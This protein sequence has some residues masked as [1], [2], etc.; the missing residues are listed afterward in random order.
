MK[1]RS[2]KASLKTSPPSLANVVVRARLI[3][4]LADLVAPA[5]WLQAPSGTGKSTLAASYV[6]EGARAVAWYRFDERDNDP[7]FFFREFASAVEAQCR[8]STALPKFLSDDHANP[9]QFARRFFATLIE[10]LQGRSV[11][12][13]DDV[14]QLTTEPM[15]ASLACLIDFA[16]ERTE[17]LLVSEP[18]APTAFFDAIAARRLAMLNDVDLHFDATECNA[19][20]ATLRIDDAQRG[21]IVAL[22]G[23]HA[24]ALVLACELLRNKDPSSVLATETVERIHSHLLSKLVERMLPRRRELLLQ[25]AFVT[26]ITRPIAAKL[27]GT[28]AAQQFDALVEAGVLRSV[29][30]DA[31]EVFEAHGLVRQGIRAFAEAHFGRTE[32]RAL[33]ER[34]ATALIQENQAEA[35]FALLIEIDSTSRALE[36]L[37]QLAETYAAQGQTE[38]LM[39]SVAKLPSAKVQ[40]NAW[41][42][43]WVGQALLRVDEDR[44]RVWFG[45]AYAAFEASSDTYGMRLAAASIVTAFGLETGDLRGL[46]LWLARHEG[47]GGDKP[48]VAGDRFEASLLM[49]V[50]CTAFVRGTPPSEEERVIARMRSLIDVDSAWLSDD[51]RVQA[52]RLLI[53][54]ALVFSNAELGRIFIVA[55][56]FLIK[57]ELGSLLHRGRWLI[58]A[59]QKLSDTGDVEEA[60]EFLIEARI[61][62]EQANSPRLSFELGLFFAD[63]WM[64][65]QELDRAANELQL[66]E[67]IVGN[68]PPAQRAEYARIYARIHLLQERFPEGL[69]WAEEARRMAIPAGYSR[70]Y[71][72]SFD[73]ELTYALAANDRLAEAIEVVRGIE[74]EPREPLLAIENCLRFLH[75]GSTDLK[76]LRDGVAMARQVGFF[77]LLDRARLPLARICELAL[78]NDIERDFVLRL[79]SLKQIKP[80]PDTG[81]AWPWPVHIRTLGGFRLDIDGKRYRPTHKAQDKPLELLKLLVSCQ[82]LGRQSADKSWAAERLWPQADGENARKSLDMTV[83]RL[84]KLLGRDEAIVSNEGRLQLSPLHV[85]TDVAPFLRALLQASSR[86]DDHMAGKRNDIEEVTAS[87]TAVLDHY[88]GP[89]LADEDGPP[90][91]LAGREAMASA[92]RHALLTADALLDGTSDRLLIPALEKAFAV[93]PTSED[94]ARSLM[95]AHL[96]QGHHSEVLRV[97]RRLRETLSLLLSIAPSAETDHIRQQAYAAE[98]DA[99]TTKAHLSTT[100]K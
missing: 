87:V 90:W 12:V 64:K 2:Y 9:V 94:L 63:H 47:A 6:A 52:A 40:N 7:A 56:Q 78:A 88:T 28:E 72:R 70:A 65:A 18:S 85:W 95:R 58:A 61:L 29:G 20:T 66:L 19:M 33:A 57:Q 51:Q 35:A 21:K 42:C 79:I 77:N 24:G 82:T 46:D 15:L 3:D 75:G 32:A 48:V 1:E 80:R 27:A 41:L 45:Y 59:A 81:P 92:V 25:T 26:Q 50:M 23:G 98:A 22:T 54:H 99:S 30:A 17:V 91:M 8:L 16:N 36:T 43:F 62:A 55:T 89:Y 93:D 69:R 14:H 39:T 49:G 37:Q 34:T 97:Y 76:L 96:R 5:K 13:L 60:R 10:Q 83:A 4:A 11:L 53:E 44:A 67:G 68:V 31:L 84:R 74:L 73:V 100:N 71:L 38:L 86:R